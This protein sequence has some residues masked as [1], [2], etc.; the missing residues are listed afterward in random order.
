MAEKISALD[1]FIIC[2]KCDVFE[3]RCDIWCDPETTT[4]HYSRYILHHFPKFQYS[5]IRHDPPFN[6]EG[7]WDWTRTP[8]RALIHV[9]R[10]TSRRVC[11]RE[12]GSHLHR[13]GTRKK[14]PVSA[15]YCKRLCVWAWQLYWYLLPLPFSDAPLYRG[16]HL[17][18]PLLAVDCL[19]GERARRPRTVP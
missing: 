7:R 14:D 9:C 16:P 17:H 18:P 11:K 19:N 4:S 10:G 12:S 1:H 3:I 15:R 2:C 13:G 5:K 6:F 8:R